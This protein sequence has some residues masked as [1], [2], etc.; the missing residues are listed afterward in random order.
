M[1]WVDYHEKDLIAHL[2]TALGDEKAFRICNL[3][4]GDV[5][6]GRDSIMRFLSPR[7]YTAYL[8]VR[9]C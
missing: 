2:D 7:I 3:P 8:S 6:I 4:I 9:P 1:I 5:A